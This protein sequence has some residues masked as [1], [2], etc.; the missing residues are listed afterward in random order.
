M[1]ERSATVML[2]SK[3]YVANVVRLP[4][5][6]NVMTAAAVAVGA[7]IHINVPSAISGSNNNSTPY[8]AKLPIICMVMSHI[9]RRSM[10]SSR[11]EMRQ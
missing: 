5:N 2:L 8:T 3:L 10:R 1:G 11:K 9:C 7:K 6:M 4:P